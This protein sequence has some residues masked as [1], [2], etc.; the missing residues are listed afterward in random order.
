M[1][2]IE[3]YHLLSV[4]KAEIFLKGWALI[5]HDALCVH[6]F[7]RKTLKVR[8]KLP[9]MREKTYLSEGL[10][11]WPCGCFTWTFDEVLS[12]CFGLRA[13][14]LWTCLWWRWLLFI[15][16]CA[17]IVGMNS[18]YLE[19][20]KRKIGITCVCLFPSTFANTT[21]MVVRSSFFFGP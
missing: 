7:G 4:A 20:C 14:L 5:L 19:D 17:R 1:Y 12:R 2:R 3:V 8:Q 6:P 15:P 18:Y 11:V 21:C 9:S 16:V 10:L 13:P